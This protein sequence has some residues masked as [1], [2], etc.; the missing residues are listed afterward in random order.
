VL[1]GQEYWRRAFDIDYLLDE[2]VI[3]AED[4]DLFWFAEEAEE[5]WEG[6]LSWYA[7]NGRPLL[8]SS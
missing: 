4:I 6:I 3:D 7:S 8:G 2:G 5:V 1:V